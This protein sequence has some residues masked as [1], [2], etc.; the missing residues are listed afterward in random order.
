MTEDEDNQRAVAVCSF[1]AGS[2]SLIAVA[3]LSSPRGCHYGDSGRS[4]AGAVHSRGFHYSSG[5]HPA[6][7]HRVGHGKRTLS[8]WLDKVRVS[9]AYVERRP[10][11]CKAGP[12]PRTL[13]MNILP[14]NSPEGSAEDGSSC[15][16]SVPLC[17][18]AEARVSKFDITSIQRACAQG[19][20]P[21]A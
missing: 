5:H 7:R 3:V 2:A 8:C 9:H 1:A 16:D 18:N 21:H 11:T 20:F 14:A 15:S 4:R 6:I 10:V 19:R 13:V 12:E 17:P